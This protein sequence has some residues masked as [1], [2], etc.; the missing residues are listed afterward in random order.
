MRTLQ[1]NIYSEKLGKRPRMLIPKGWVER[2]GNTTYM[3]EGKDFMIIIP[4][5][6]LTKAMKNKII[7][8]LKK[9]I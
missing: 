2:N 5:G 8:E 3:L 6:K 1:K 4:Q 7:E 9:E